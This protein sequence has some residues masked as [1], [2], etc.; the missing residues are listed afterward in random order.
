VQRQREGPAHA[1]AGLKFK[2]LRIPGQRESEQMC[3]VW[4]PPAS[5]TYV[6]DSYS[7]TYYPYFYDFTACQIEED[8]HCTGDGCVSTL[9]APAHPRD[10]AVKSY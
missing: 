8:P 5:D 4:V 3:D 7:Y 9:R 10:H 1:W 2:L 6:M